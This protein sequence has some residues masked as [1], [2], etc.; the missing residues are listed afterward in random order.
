[1]IPVLLT[2]AMIT[3]HL[4]KVATLLDLG[5]GNYRQALNAMAAATPGRLIKASGDGD[6]QIGSML[7]FYG[8]FLRPAKHV[9]YIPRVKVT[10]EK[11]EWFVVFSFFR[12]IP[13]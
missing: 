7:D 5:R 11:P 3:G 12:P 1:M 6:F 8:L 2:F 4:L 10:L 13:I 9:E